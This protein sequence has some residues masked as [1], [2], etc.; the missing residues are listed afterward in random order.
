MDEY[1]RSLFGSAEKWRV[2]MFIDKMKELQKNAVINEIEAFA[3]L[4]ARSAYE[5]IRDKS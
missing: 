1:I 5:L 3:I 2:E 4:A